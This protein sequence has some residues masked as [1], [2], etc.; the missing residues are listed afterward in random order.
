MAG[1]EVIGEAGNGAEAIHYTQTS[2]PDLILMDI[3]MPIMSGFEAARHIKED[4]PSTKIVLVTIHDNSTYQALATLLQV[5]GFVCK[6]SLKKD[7]PKVLLQLTS[8][9]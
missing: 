2:H 8:S 1:L 3:S 5:D 6:S 7:L 4:A 9:S